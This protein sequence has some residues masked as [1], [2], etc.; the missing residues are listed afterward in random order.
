MSPF[1][2]IERVVETDSIDNCEMSLT[3]ADME[4][5]ARNPLHSPNIPLVLQSE[6]AD[7]QAATSLIADGPVLAELEF[8]KLPKKSRYLKSFE[9]RREKNSLL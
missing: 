7:L 4:L 3:V 1:D 5:S 8:K 6:L 9:P 2:L